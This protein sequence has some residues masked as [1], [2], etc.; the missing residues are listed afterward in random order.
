MARAAATAV[1]RVACADVVGEHR[2]RA[3]LDQLLVVALHGAV[4]LA[5]VDRVAVAIGEHLD[6]DVATALDQ[7]LEEHALVAERAAGLALGLGERGLDLVGP[8][9]MRMPRPPPPLSALSKTG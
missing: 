9:A 3:L 1:A 5:D 2:R 8:R 4:A 6:L 7:P